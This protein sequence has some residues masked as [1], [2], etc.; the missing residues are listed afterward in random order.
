MFCGEGLTNLFLSQTY[1]IPT[2]TPSVP[3]WLVGQIK[4][5]EPV[6]IW[7]RPRWDRDVVPY[8]GEN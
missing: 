8:F 3:H 1:D 4:G 5:K 6:G 7:P 2:L